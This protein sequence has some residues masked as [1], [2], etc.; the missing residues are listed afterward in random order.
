[1]PIDLVRIL[2]APLLLLAGAGLV[3]GRLTTLA[4]DLQLLLAALPYL[5]GATNLLLAYLYN[6][7]RAMLSALNLLAGY[8]LIQQCLQ[9]PLAEPDNFVLF[10]LLS[11]L[12]PF[13]QL[14]FCLAP[15]RGLRNRRA[16]AMKLLPLAPFALLGLLWQQHWLAPWLY[17][18]PAP[19]HELAVEARYLSTAS[20]W[21]CAVALLLGALV[22][23]F[24]RTHADGAMLGVLLTL[25]ALF[26]W[27]DQPLISPLLFSTM[28][29]VLVQALVFHSH[30][31]AFVDELTGIPARRALQEQL[32]SLGR[33]YTIAM[34]DIDHFKRF[35]DRYGHDAGDQVLRLVASKLREVSGGG[36]VFRYGGEEF[37]VL[38]RGKSEE[39]A[40]PHLEQLREAIAGYPLQIRRSDRPDDVDAGRRQRS[41]GASGKPVQVTISIGLCERGPTHSDPDAVLQQADKAL[42]AAKKAGR[43]RTVPSRR[44]R[45]RSR[46]GQSDFA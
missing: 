20:A 30:Q 12:L 21:F 27:F 33:R 9:S 32:R 24:R 37:T 11:L 2:I 22:L 13:N 5:L 26:F 29:L 42:Y 19:L 15:E 34:M 8:A 18:L 38:F 44:L 17:Q 7:S 3:F 46:R 36:R 39:D 23:H 6:Q 45:Q 14:L 16:L 1:M 25:P 40:L 31:L 43:N 10:S 41:S 4:P 28:Q 35:N